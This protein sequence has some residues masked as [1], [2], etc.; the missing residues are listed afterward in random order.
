MDDTEVQD[1]CDLSPTIMMQFLSARHNVFQ[2]PNLRISPNAQRKSHSAQ[3]AS[4]DF[5]VFAYLPEQRG[6][7][8]IVTSFRGFSLCC[9]WSCMRAD[10]P[11]PIGGTECYYPVE[12]TP[13]GASSTPEL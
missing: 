6:N 11:L 13:P 1:Y 7:D 5:G 9:L 10:G 2:R 12:A 8:A 4:S 3:L